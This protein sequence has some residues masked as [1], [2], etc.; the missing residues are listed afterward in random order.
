MS[1]LPINPFLYLVAAGLAGG[2]GWLV[3]QGVTAPG[4]RDNPTLAK[5]FN[6]REAIGRDRK[7]DDRQ[8][9]YNGKW[10]TGFRDVNFIGKLPP[11]PET[12]DPNPVKPPEPELKEIAIADIL[13]VECIVSGEQKD[14][15]VVVRYRPEANVTPPESP[16]GTRPAAGNPGRGP[17]P[18]DFT[19]ERRQ[20]L[21]LEAAL[22]APYGHIRLVRV[23]EDGASVFFRREDPKAGGG[24]AKEEEVFK[25][26]AQLDQEV[27]KALVRGGQKE[28]RQPEQGPNPDA[29]SVASGWQE[30]PQTREVRPRE[31]MISRDDHDYLRTNTERVLEDLG[32]DHYKGQRYRGV[33]VTR[34]PSRL[35][36]FGVSTGDVVLEVNNVPVETKAQAIQV[37][38]RQY[39]MGVRTFRVKLLSRGRVEERTFYAQD[40]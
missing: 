12:V 23:A 34:V 16:F 10:W 25:A 11:E 15:K 20:H 8:D 5:L 19:A 29:A 38:K 40:K 6:E 2:I 27:I 17:S 14:T 24:E 1:K 36:Q 21:T 35:E 4:S 13:L 39:D 22:W 37:G 9:D 32:L 33:M 3:Y 26:V 31:W 28:P 30:V 7:S 18:T